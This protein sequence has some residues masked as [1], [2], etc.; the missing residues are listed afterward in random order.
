MI[1]DLDDFIANASKKLGYDSGERRG[2][3]G[4]GRGRGGAPERPSKEL[5]GR[6]S[7]ELPHNPSRDSEPHFVSRPDDPLGLRQPFDSYS[8][9]PDDEPEII[10][11]R[12]E[13]VEGHRHLERHRRRTGQI[14]SVL[15]IG[16]CVPC[17]C[18]L[19]LWEREA[20]VELKLYTPV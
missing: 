16:Y 20:G 15:S 10:E 14:Q 1:D 18:V 3:R 7:W 6:H 9:T 19:R 8:E 17:Y 4:G 2:G 12:K 5:Q 13:R 11:V